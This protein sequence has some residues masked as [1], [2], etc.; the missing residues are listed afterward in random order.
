[1]NPVESPEPDLDW[2][3][4]AVQ[5]VS[6]TFALTVDV[7]DE[8]MASHVCL[9]YLLCRVADTIED[10]NHIPP[11]EQAALLRTYDAALDPD[12][13]TT[14]TEFRAAAEEW[15][16]APADRDE[17]WAVVAAAPTVWATFTEQPEPVRDAIV[18]PIREMVDGM[19]MFVERHADTGGL[20]L[21]DRSEL[22]EYCYYAAGT[23]GILIT[24]LLTRRGVAEERAETLYGTAEE[25][26]LLLQLINVSKD[27]YDDY[28]SENN[29]YLPATWFEE[30]GIDQEAV[31]DPAARESAASVVHRTATHA[32]TFLDDAQTYLESM[33]LSHGNKTA[34]WSVPF[35]LGVGTLRE[36]KA[37]PEDALTESG[38]KISRREVF[39]V[40]EA[41]HDAGADSLTGLRE[42]VARKPYH[43]ATE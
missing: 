26:G 2:C 33:P 9:G 10:A 32:A 7:L 38:V 42:T 29:V 4:E 12:S 36:L 39:A 21:D 30:E 24:N 35:L 11:A 28:T 19:A 14:I 43:H 3:H 22:E 34:A 27:A 8:P 1:M 17:D 15:L 13:E 18:A 23:V 41:A 6:R 40:M 37:R 20:R 25:F 31:V 5:G 16:P